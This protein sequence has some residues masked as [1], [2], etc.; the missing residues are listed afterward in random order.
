MSGR[1]IEISI[2]PFSFKEYLTARNI[3]TC[4]KYLNFEALFF[5]YVNET[6]LVIQ[7]NNTTNYDDGYIRNL[8][9]IEYNRTVKIP[10]REK[11]S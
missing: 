3:D 9:E 2:L 10:K 5:D 7:F 6:S 1:Y 4:N 8:S 11:S